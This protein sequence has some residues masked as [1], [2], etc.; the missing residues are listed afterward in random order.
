MA[1]RFGNFIYW[2]ATIIALIIAAFGAWAVVDH[3]LVADP[4]WIIIIPLWIVA[5]VIWAIGRGVRYVLGA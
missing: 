5:F 3:P 4:V 1:A 2:A